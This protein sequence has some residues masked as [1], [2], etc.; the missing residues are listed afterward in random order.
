[1]IKLS[2][3]Y[4]L[5]IKPHP[6]FENFAKINDLYSYFNDNN[7]TVTNESFKKCLN[8][9]DILVSFSSTTIEEKALYN[10]RPVILYDKHNRYS[11]LD[12]KIF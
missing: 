5:I 11:H 3:N 1:M 7:F 12:C 2:L 9:S 8:K 4:K 6:S 10:H